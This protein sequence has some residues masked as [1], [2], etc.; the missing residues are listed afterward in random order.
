MWRHFLDELGQVATVIRY[1]ER[2]H[3]LSDRDVDDHRL[4]RRVEDLEAVVD[5][6][7]HDRFALMAMAQG[8][9]VAIRYAATHPERVTRAVFYDTFAAASLDFSADFEA[10]NDAFAQLIRVGWGRPHSE[11]RRVF[12]SMMIPSGTEEQL[13]WLDELL[14]VASTADAA[15]AAR[16]EWNRTD[17]TELLAKLGMPTLVLHTRHNRVIEFEHGRLLASSIPGSRLVT[18]DSDNHIVLGH[19]PAWRTFVDEVT[20]FLAPDRTQHDERVD[21]AALLS[22]REREVLELAATGLGNDEIAGALVVSVRT[23]ERHLQNVYVKLGVSG[24]TARAAA[25]ARLLS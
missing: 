14:R 12:S 16:R 22:E 8:G 6:A 9:P 24:K 23:V 10:M 4:E 2:G 25:V 21:V 18:L 15:I 13:Q 19:E 11:F 20:A 5:A 3:G 17:A 1:D 7:G